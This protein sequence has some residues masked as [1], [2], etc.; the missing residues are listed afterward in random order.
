MCILELNEIKKVTQISDPDIV[1]KMLN[2]GWVLLAVSKF[3][4]Y[5]GPY[6]QEIVYYSVG[7]AD[8]AADPSTYKKPS[9]L[10]PLPPEWMG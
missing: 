6:P 2:D 8:P 3:D 5:G 4:S 1:N 10:P 7:T 9:S